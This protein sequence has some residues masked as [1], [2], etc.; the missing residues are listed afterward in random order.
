MKIA[1]ISGGSST[2]AAVSD[3]NASYI[4]EAL[5]RLGYT[6][7]RLSYD[8]TLPETL[9]RERPE[10]VFLCVQGKGHGDGTCQGLLDFFGI[11]YTGSGREAATVINNKILCQ[12]LFALEGLPIA[13]NFFWR[14]ADQDRPDAAEEFERRLAHAGFTFPCVVKAPTQGGSFG[15]VL[16]ENSAQLPRLADPFRY[17]ETLLAEEFIPGPFYTVGLLADANGGVEAL[18]VME[19]VDLDRGKKAMITFD[20]KYTAQPAAISEP[21]TQE[22]QTLALRVFELTGARDYARVDFMLDERDGS[23]RILEIN[24]VPGLKP[25]SLY[26][27]A[28]ALA[29]VS[30]DEMIDRIM[31]ACIERGK[32]HA[33]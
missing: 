19:G 6:V 9:R 21:L 8:E 25:Q 1:T 7:V 31:R 4:A 24:A 30:Y 27:P 15:I 20:G 3:K 18:P 16:L 14:Q 5:A 11:P 17:D 10:A 33:S 26:P 32:A 23:P 2:E 13:H 12:K 29:G 28:A 22:L